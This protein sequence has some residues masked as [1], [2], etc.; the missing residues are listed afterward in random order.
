[1]TW[2]PLLGA[3]TPSTRPTRPELAPPPSSTALPSP[4]PLA[5]T[6]LPIGVQIFEDDVTTPA[7]EHLRAAGVAWARTRALWK[8]I[9]PEPRD[10]PAYDWSVTDRLFGDATAAG[11]RNLAVVYANPA[12]VS[13][14]ECLPVPPAHAERYAAFWQA[15]VERYDGDG[16]ADAPNGAVVGWWQVGNEPDFDP[17]SAA[18]ATEG[19]YGSCFGD[20]PAA[21]AEQLRRAALAIRAADPGARIGFGPLA[22]DRFTAETA[23]AGWTAPPGPFAADFGQRALEH[24]YR[25]HA[26]EPGLPFFDFV[27]LHS[28]N[29]NAHFWDGP[30]PPLASELLGR[31][32]AFRAEQLALPGVYD[33]R[34][35]PILVSETGLAS[36]PSD[37]W[38]ERGEDWQAV[39][40]GQ[41]MVRAQAAGVVAA[42]WYTARDNIVGDCL[43]PHWDWLSFGLMRADDYLDA[44][45][46][47]CPAQDWVD[48]EAYA[49]GADGAAPKPALEALANLTRALGGYSFERQLS[50]SETGSAAIEAYRFRGPGGRTL[51]A[52]WTTTGARLGRRGDERITAR[53]R[54]DARWLA[55]W[56]GRVS[57]RPHLGPAVSLGADGEASVELLVNQA[58]VYLTTE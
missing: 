49:P 46:S 24:L 9:E 13:Q 25:A 3:C 28:Y 45:R 5:R 1:M 17:R 41:T 33:L 19:D 43:P 4:E 23:P 40:V 34:R 58:P 56:T 42:I 6:E 53:L 27:G 36:G 51:L 32:A 35:M 22:W 18:A 39:Y 30:E 44:L 50:A 52:A 7:L 55:P 10:P 48:A 20:D 38:T 26:G 37:E 54:V 29:D 12:W 2:L 15:L 57:A 8:L 21:Y 31:L 14:P 11:F 47:R 16:R